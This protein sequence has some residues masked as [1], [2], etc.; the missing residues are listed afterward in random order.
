[1]DLKIFMLQIFLPCAAS[2]PNVFDCEE[3]FVIPL[4]GYIAPDLHSRVETPKWPLRQRRQSML[5]RQYMK[6]W[7]CCV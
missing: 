4:A 7:D 6:R 1:M 3:S 2:K 5:N